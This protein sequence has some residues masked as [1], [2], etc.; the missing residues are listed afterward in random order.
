MPGEACSEGAHSLPTAAAGSGPGRSH[1][2]DADAPDVTA[3]PHRGSGSDVPG[4]DFVGSGSNWYTFAMT[5][6][7]LSHWYSNVDHSSSVLVST[8][9]TSCTTVSV[10]ATDEAHAS[11]LFSS[12]TATAALPVA[13]QTHV[14]IETHAEVEPSHDQAETHTEATAHVQS[15]SY[16]VDSVTPLY[17]VHVEE[18]ATHVHSSHVAESDSTVAPVWKPSATTAWKDGCHHND[19][20]GPVTKV[21]GPVATGGAANIRGLGIVIATMALGMAAALM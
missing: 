13:T 7:F 6:R 12:Y 16:A 9:V 14:L 19:T 4:V 17:S 1:S 18:S 11:H 5:H 10:S 8:E 3:P 15:S 20:V 21:P 2:H